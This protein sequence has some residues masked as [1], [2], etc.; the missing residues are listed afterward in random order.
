MCFIFLFKDA[1]YL[2]AAVREREEELCRRTLQAFS[3]MRI[4][5]PGK[6][7]EEAEMILENVSITMATKKY[8]HDNLCMVT[9]TLNYRMLLFFKDSRKLEIPQTASSIL[10]AGKT[11]FYKKAKG[12]IVS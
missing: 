3:D 9:G 5:F 8:H 4:K 12:K 6:T 1:A 2:N 10:L 11:W 7:D